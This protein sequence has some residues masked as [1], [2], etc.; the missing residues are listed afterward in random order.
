MSMK[1]REDMILFNVL[2][3]EVVFEEYFCNLLQFDIFRNLFL[4]FVGIADK[5]IK[6]ENFSTETILSNEC[7]RAD[8]FLQT[9]NETFIFEIKNKC[10]TELTIN[11]PNK[12]I[13]YL[14]YKSEY[15]LF[16][17]P[18]GYKHTNKINESW[19][20]DDKFNGHEIQILFWEDFINK[21]RVSKIYENKIEIKQFYDFC[22][23]WFN[24]EIIKFTNEEH[25]FLQKEGRRMINISVPKFIEKLEYIIGNIGENSN[26]KKDANAVAINYSKVINDYIIYFGIDYDIWDKDNEPLTLIIQNHSNNF[27]RFDLK[28]ENEV[29]LPIEYEETNISEKQF[30]Y[31]VKLKSDLGNDDFQSEIKK[32]IKHI[33]QILDKQTERSP[34]IH[35]DS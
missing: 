15:L 2:N 3:L 27:E 29:L 23:Y 1:R 30:A 20:E 11:Q 28:I 4:D 6:Y 10:Y 26:M 7:G 31:L 16:L 5:N 8:L 12:Y 21:I 14:N 13:E 17:I 33:S 9:E 19:R 35:V 18:E 34:F 25:N 22:L 32:Q 24:M